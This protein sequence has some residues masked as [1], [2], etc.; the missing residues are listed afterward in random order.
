MRRL[1]GDRAALK[2]NHLEVHMCTYTHAC[3]CIYMHIFM[4]VNARTE[5]GNAQRR[6]SHINCKH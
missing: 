2:I 1:D 6:H 5:E 4:H 3:M